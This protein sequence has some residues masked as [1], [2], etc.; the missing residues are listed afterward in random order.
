M[1]SN[2][3]RDFVTACIC[4]SAVR[5]HGRF[6]GRAHLSQRDHLRGKCGAIRRHYFSR[7]CVGRG[8]A[9]R[10]RRRSARGHLRTR[11]QIM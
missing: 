5:R 8:G 6:S 4:L 2:Y 3:L 1:K 9:A 7:A 10:C 11:A